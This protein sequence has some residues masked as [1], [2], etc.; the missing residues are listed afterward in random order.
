VIRHDSGAQD[1]SEG[2]E[3]GRTI[4]AIRAVLESELDEPTAETRGS[5]VDKPD[6]D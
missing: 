2:R 6:P 3:R 1:S 4:D 5:F